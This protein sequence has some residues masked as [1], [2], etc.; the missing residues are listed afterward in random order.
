MVDLVEDDDRSRA[1]VLLE[2]VDE[3]I[4][5]RRLPV[6]VDSGAEVVEDLVEC[7]ESG[8]VAPAVD[9]GSLNVED[10]FPV[11]VR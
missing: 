11:V 1:I 6:D 8:V 9:V 10:L 4:V 5:R 7:P 2:A 3:F